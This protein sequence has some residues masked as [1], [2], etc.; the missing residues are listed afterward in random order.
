MAPSISSVANIL[1]TVVWYHLDNQNLENALFFAERLQAQEARAN[2]E[3]TYLI[4]LCYFRLGDYSSACSIT[5]LV[6]LRGQHLGCAYIFAQSCLGLELFKD[7]I[8]AL[9][10]TSP[11]WKDAMSLGKHSANTRCLPDK[12]SVLC[13]LGKL[14]RGF[15]DYKKAIHCFEDALKANPFMWDAITNLCEMN[16]E[17][18]VPGIYRF[19][20]P[21]FS[22][23][24]PA[25][26]TIE[27]REPMS[28]YP[29]ILAKKTGLRN[30]MVYDDPFEPH[31]PPQFHQCL[32]GTEESFEQLHCLASRSCTMEQDR[33]E[34]PT[35]SMSRSDTALAQANHNAEAPQAPLRRTRTTHSHDTSALE[36]PPKIASRLSRRG[37]KTQV[38]ED[39]QADTT[40]SQLVKSQGVGGIS[41][42]ERKRT[43]SGQPR[44]IEEP[45]APQRRSQ[46]I[47]GMLFKGS[48]KTNGI[49]TTGLA[50]GRELRKA[51]APISRIMRPG[52]SE[53]SVGRVVSG[54]R[55]PVEESNHGG[56]MDVDSTEPQKLREA[57]PPPPMVKAIEFESQKVEEALKGSLELFKKFTNGYVKLSKYKAEEAIKAFNSLPPPHKDSP[58]VL[59]QMGRAYYEKT[60]YAKAEVYFKKLRLAAPSRTEDMEVYS[61]VLW[62][63]KK[64]IELSFLSHELVDLDRES[65]QAW[66]AVGNAL[67]LTR[68]HEGALKSFKRATQL[69]P[70]FAYAHTL[71]GHEHVA[72]EEYDR[73]LTC[74]RNALAADPR[75]YNAY[76]GIGRVYEKMGSYDKAYTHFQAASQLNPANAV[77]VMCVGSVLEKQKQPIPALQYYSQAV[78]LSPNAAQARYKMSRALLAIGQYDRARQELMILKDLAPDEANVHFLLGKLYKTMGQNGLAIRHFTIALNLDPRVS[79]PIDIVYHPTCIIGTSV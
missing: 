66:C 31:R 11:L 32:Q 30:G 20:E 69:N 10:K 28:I 49:T 48:S 65:P 57:P 59:A 72:N 61:N 43:V 6:A 27:S 18:S 23:F 12:A 55:K 50:G 5:K 52:S 3:S 2:Y 35:S 73:A 62:F 71:Q 25:N 26:R 21:L 36:L 54:N 37:Q 29:D 13:L 46:R 74:Y 7:G 38:H 51:R 77:L 40:T 67:S 14:H 19:T 9:E 63:L 44:A 42:L 17:I 47:N 60:E 79:F 15:K 34:T 16:Q 76:Y 70:H 33:V 8:S 64:E 75:H 22:C 45:P 41:A 78:E 56:I 24:D 53:S 39:G 4:A 1:R 58:W 68:D